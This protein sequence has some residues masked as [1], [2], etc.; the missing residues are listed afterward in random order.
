ML[1]RFN[2]KKNSTSLDEAKEKYKQA[3]DEIKDYNGIQSELFKEYGLYID[4]NGQ[5]TSSTIEQAEAEKRAA[6]ESKN[7][8]DAIG[9]T[10][11]AYAAA[12]GAV[13]DVDLSEV[14][15]TQLAD[16]AA[17][18]E[19]FR[20]SFKSSLGNFSLFG[21]TEDLM[22]IYT[23]SQKSAMEKNAKIS[24]DLMGKYTDELKNLSDRGLSEEFLSYLTSQG[25]AG[26]EYVHTLATW[27]SDAELKQFQEQF[28]EFN[29]YANGTNEKVLDMM[30][31]YADNI[32]KNTMG[33]YEA[34]YAYGIQTTQGLFDAI[35]KAKSMIASGEATGELEA[36][37]KTV[38]SGQSNLA[39]ANSMTQTTLPKNN[40]SNASSAQTSGAAMPD[41]TVNTTLQIDGD[42]LAGSVTQ[43][44]NGKQKMTGRR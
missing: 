4:K 37:M 3:S 33:G 20:E 25:S 17:S 11:S 12:A 28:D 19:D 38:L 30:D 35:A 40:S 29:S 8:N 32:M 42:Q 27:T 1:N 16:A 23:S 7:L 15:K 36:V 41:I 43:K 26:L 18:V 22:D 44:I 10:A 14:V 6:E 21:D 34:W 24:L 5:M 2:P 13:A 31:S 39:I 9:T